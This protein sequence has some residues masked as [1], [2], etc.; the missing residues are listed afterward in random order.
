MTQKEAHWE[1]KKRFLF[2]F[3]YFFLSDFQLFFIVFCFFIHKG[4]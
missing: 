3:D 4:R 1:R 2:L